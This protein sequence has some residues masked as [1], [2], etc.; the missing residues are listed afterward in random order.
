MSDLIEICSKKKEIGL[1]FELENNVNLVSFKSN[2]IEISF[3]DNLDKN[4]VKNLT[5][6]LSDWTGERWIITLSKKR[7]SQSVNEIK[8]QKDKKKIKELEQN[9]SYKK[10]LKFFPDV[11]I[12][13]IKSLEEEHDE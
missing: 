5:S 8:L 10:M 2:Q 9:S 4:F 1:K 12:V 3:N 6:K 13:T 7:G 11:E